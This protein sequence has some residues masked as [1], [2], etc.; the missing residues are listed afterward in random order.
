MPRTIVFCLVMFC[1]FSLFAQ[2]IIDPEVAKKDPDF[3]VQ[4]E[5]VGS[6]LW[7]GKK[8]EVGAQVIGL[9]DHK[10]RAVVYRGGLPGAGWERGDEQ[11]TLEGELQ[12]DVTKL[13]GKDLSGEIAGGELAITSEDGKTALK[14]K[15]TV[16]QSPMLGAE[17][18]KSATVLFDGKSVEKF[19]GG[20]LTDMKTLQAGCKTKEKFT[21]QKF[22]LEFRLSWKPKARGQGRSNSG[23]FLPGIPE[24]QVLDSFGLEGKKNE[25]GAFYGRR[26]PNV[27]MCL[28]PLVWQTYDVEYKQPAADKN[29]L[30][31]VRHNGL[32]VHEDYDTGKKKFPTGNL[33]LQAHGNRVQ[34]RNIWYV[35]AE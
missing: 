31:T 12:G 3:A 28:P 6:G 26:P 20:K 16:R 9:S 29:V 11:L 25:C 19:N 24:I 35:P 15:E 33:G 8:A 17:P 22:H 2:E 13:Q 7:S 18:P 14:L 1:P 5:Y 10:F 21:P 27:N 32:V 23:V 30:V 34:Y 4:G